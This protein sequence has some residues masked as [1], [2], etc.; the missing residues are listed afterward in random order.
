MMRTLL[1]AAATLAASAA[2]AAPSGKLM[3]YTS[4]PNADAQQTIDAFGTLTGDD[5]W[6][7]TDPVRAAE[8][9]FGGPIAH[10]FL[11]LSLLAPMSLEALP[12]LTGAGMGVNYGFDRLRFLSPV[13]AGAR[14]RAHFDVTSVEE[15]R[16]GEVTFALAVTVEIEGQDRP[17]LAA[18]WINRRYMDKRTQ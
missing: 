12:G 9:P 17:A 15:T 5:Q 11:T 16:P 13:P 10:G 3:L 1:I 7:H 14:I 2:F 6:I 4:Q 18:D 8:G